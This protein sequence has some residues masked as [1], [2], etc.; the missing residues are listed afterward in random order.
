MIQRGRRSPIPI[1]KKE[2]EIIMAKDAYQSPHSQRYAGKE[3][4]Y[5]FSQDM[6]FITWRK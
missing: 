4:K 5:F 6:K 1:F 3:M 2:K